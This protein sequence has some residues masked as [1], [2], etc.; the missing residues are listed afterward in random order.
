MDVLKPGTALALRDH[1][2]L[3]DGLPRTG[4]RERVHDG[5]QITSWTASVAAE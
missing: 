2:E 3:L 4:R 5:V 1:P